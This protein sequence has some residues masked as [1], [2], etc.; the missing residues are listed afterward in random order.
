MRGIKNGG[1]KNAKCKIRNAKCGGIQ[2]VGLQ[3]RRMQNCKLC[4]KL[5]RVERLA[6]N[7]GNLQET[8]E[9]LI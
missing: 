6:K 9:E 1:L 5:E 7:T 3:K 8:Q 4:E 2:K